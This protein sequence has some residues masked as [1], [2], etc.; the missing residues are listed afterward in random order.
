[1]GQFASQMGNIAG[2]GIPGAMGGGGGKRK[3]L[4]G[5]PQLQN[6]LGG[7]EAWSLPMEDLFRKGK[8]YRSRELAPGESRAGRLQESMLQQT[9]SLTEQFGPLFQD[10]ALEMQQRDPLLRQARELGLESLEEQRRVLGQQA[11]IIS[12]GLEGLEEGG[13]PDDVRKYVLEEARAI[14]GSRGLLESPSS[15]LFETTSLVKQRENLRSIRLGQADAFLSGAQG[16]AAPGL[17]LGQGGQFFGPMMPGMNQVVSAGLPGLIASHA[18]HRGRSAAGQ[19]MV[20]QGLG[21]LGG[22]AIGSFAGPMGSA[23]GGM[24][25]GMF[26]G[27][28]AGLAGMGGT[29]PTSSSYSPFGF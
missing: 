17:S 3:G 29:P 26:G 8:G 4:G 1:M 16:L 2:L 20:G 14:G 5:N 27:G 13:L 21:Q 19:Q 15:A 24:F 9:L 18:A 25:G 22:M 23:I 11:D 6:L 12:G 10:M 28:S 7:L